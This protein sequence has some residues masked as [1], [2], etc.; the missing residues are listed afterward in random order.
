MWAVSWGAMA[1]EVTLEKVSAMA[2]MSSVNAVEAVGTVSKSLQSI[3]TSSSVSAPESITQGGAEQ[4]VAM[5]QVITQGWSESDGNASLVGTQGLEGETGKSGGNGGQGG[6]GGGAFDACV[7]NE[8]V[9]STP[10]FTGAGGALTALIDS[11]Y[12]YVI[13]NGGSGFNKS[14]ASKEMFG[15][16]AYQYIVRDNNGDITM[17]TFGGAG[18]RPGTTGPWCFTFGP[19]GGA[20]GSGGAG[21]DSGNSGVSGGNGDKLGGGGGG[22]GGAG[23]ISFFNSPYSNSEFGA[24]APQQP[25]IEKTSDNAE[26]YNSLLV[27]SGNGNSGGNGGNGGNGGLGGDYGYFNA[28]VRDESDSNKGL[29]WP[30]GYNQNILYSTDASQTKV[31]T[32]YY[33]PGSYGDFGQSMHRDRLCMTNVS[34][35]LS[36]KVGEYF[37]DGKSYSVVDDPPP[38]ISSE[39]MG[40]ILFFFRSIFPQR[41][42]DPSSTSRSRPSQFACTINSLPSNSI[43]VLLQTEYSGIHNILDGS[44]GVFRGCDGECDFNFSAECTLMAPGPSYG[45]ANFER[46]GR[47]DTVD[48][49]EYGGR[50]IIP[51]YSLPVLNYLIEKTCDA[52]WPLGGII[53]DKSMPSQIIGSN[54]SDLGCRAKDGLT[55]HDI[56]EISTR[57]GETN[58]YARSMQDILLSPNSWSLKFMGWDPVGLTTDATD[59]GLGA[60]GTGGGGGGGGGGTGQRGQDAGRGAN[61]SY[62][63]S[64]TASINNV[65]IKNGDDSL[66]DGLRGAVG[67]GTVLNGLGKGGKG[68]AGGKHGDMDST[69]SKGERGENGSP[70]IGGEG[71]LPSKAGDTSA[72]FNKLFTCQLSVQRK[73]QSM[74]VMIND[75]NIKPDCPGATS[76]NLDGTSNSTNDVQI[77]TLNL[78]GQNTLNVFSN[79][80][81]ASI[82]KINYDADSN[83]DLMVSYSANLPIGQIIVSPPKVRLTNP[84][85]FLGRNYIDPYD[86][87]A[88]FVLLQFP[89]LPSSQIAGKK[90]TLKGEDVATGSGYI[91]RYV[92]TINNSDNL[93]DQSSRTARIPLSAFVAENPCLYGSDGVVLNMPCTKP[94]RATLPHLDYGK[95]YT[96]GIDQGAFHMYSASSD[97]YT[98]I[99]EGMYTAGSLNL[100]EFRTEMPRIGDVVIT[101]KETSL[102]TNNCVA[103]REGEFDGLFTGTIKT[104]GSSNNSL[105]WA[106]YGNESAQ[107]RI[108]NTVPTQ[109]GEIGTS[110]TQLCIDLRETSP[111]V[112]VMV[113]SVADD[114]K[115]DFAIVN[116]N[117]IEKTTVQTL[118]PIDKQSNVE[119]G[120]SAEYI[121]SYTVREQGYDSSDEGKNNLLISPTGQLSP[122]TTAESVGC[123]PL[124]DDTLPSNHPNRFSKTEFLCRVRLNIAS[125]ESAALV[126][127]T[128]T[129]AFDARSSDYVLVSVGSAA[130][131][132]G[133][134]V[135]TPP[136][137]LVD[138]STDGLSGT[139][140]VKLNGAAVA[141]CGNPAQPNAP[142]SSWGPF[143][144]SGNL[145]ESTSLSNYIKVSNSEY[146]ITVNPSPI[147]EAAQLTVTFTSCGSQK[148]LNFATIDLINPVKHGLV[149][150]PQTQVFDFA[151]DYAAAQK[152]ASGN[153]RLEFTQHQIVQPGDTEAVKWQIL[154]AKSARTHFD[155]GQPSA[156]SQTISKGES[157]QLFL[158]GD[159][160][161]NVIFVVA[162]LV[163]NPA[164]VS[165]AIV[166]IQGQDNPMLKYAN[167]VAQNVLLNP[168]GV[169]LVNVQGVLRLPFGAISGDDEVIFSVYGATSGSTAVTYTGNCGSQFL[170][171]CGEVQIAHNETAN[172]ILVVATLKNYPHIRDTL[173]VNIASH[174]S[175]GI[176]LEADRQSVDFTLSPAEQTVNLTA[177]VDLPSENNQK[178]VIFSIDGATSTVLTDIQHS[179]LSPVTTATLIIGPDESARTI[180]ITAH[181]VFNPA[182]YATIAVNVTSNSAIGVEFIDEIARTGGLGEVMTDAE[183][184]IR[185]KAVAPVGVDKTKIKWE[186]F[187]QT[188]GTELTGVDSYLGYTPILGQ[189]ERLAVLKVNS[190]EQS[191]T[192][193]LKASFEDDASY[194]AFATLNVSGVVTSGIQL[195]P[196][197]AKLILPLKVAPELFT[198]YPIFDY[199]NPLPVDES[200]KI[201]YPIKYFL[202]PI[203]ERGHPYTEDS[204]LNFNMC[205]LRTPASIGILTSPYSHSDEHGNLYVTPPGDYSEEYGLTQFDQN[206]DMIGCE[207][208]LTFRSEISFPES[209]YRSE[210]DKEKGAGTFISEDE[211]RKRVNTV[212]FQVVGGVQEPDGTSLY[213]GDWQNVSCQNDTI[214]A[215][216]HN[217]SFRTTYVE[218][219]CYSDGYYT[220]LHVAFEEVATTLWVVARST[221]DQSK[222]AISK[223]DVVNNKT[224]GV[225]INERDVRVDLR[226]QNSLHTYPNN[227]I[228][229]STVVSVPGGMSR[230]VQWS[231]LGGVGVSETTSEATFITQD[232]VLKISPQEV[233][234]TLYV[235]ARLNYDPTKFDRVAVRLYNHQTSGVR[236]LG[237]KPI[238]FCING[239]SEDCIKRCI[240]PLVDH[241][242]SDES[243]N[244]DEFTE[245]QSDEVE[246]SEQPPTFDC[247]RG[248]N[249]NDP[250]RS[251]VGETESEGEISGES[252]TEDG[253]GSEP[254]EN[255]TKPV[256]GQGGEKIKPM[257]YQYILEVNVSIPAEAFGDADLEWTV[258]GGVEG[259]KID[260]YYPD[261]Y[262]PDPLSDGT[263]TRFGILTVSQFES[264]P[265]LNIV[266]RLKFDPTR[267]DT[268]EVKVFGRNTTGILVSPHYSEVSVGKRQGFEAYIS[269]PFKETEEVVWQVF[270]GSPETEITTDGILIIDPYE[271]S[272]NVYV[273]ATLVYD[274]TRF[275]TAVVHILDRVTSGVIISP[276]EPIISAGSEHT[277]KCQ[278]FVPEH[279]SEYNSF[280]ANN[281]S[282]YKNFTSF[283]N[284]TCEFK[285]FGGVEGTQI[286]AKTGE[287]KVND[288]ETS[289][290]LGVMAYSADEPHLKD[291]VAVQVSGRQGKGVVIDNAPVQKAGADAIFT[292]TV[293]TPEG[294]SKDV[295]WSVSGGDPKTTIDAETG[296]LHVANSELSKHLTVIAKSVYNPNMIDVVDVRVEGFVEPHIILSPS[297]TMLEPG[298]LM[299]FEAKVE[300]PSDVDSSVVW[301]VN[302]A[303]SSATAIING[304]LSIA[305]D[306]T[307][308]TLIVCGALNYDH[309]IHNCVVVYVSKASQIVK[310]R[311]ANLSTNLISST[312]LVYTK[313]SASTFTFN[314]P[315]DLRLVD[316]IE[317]DGMQ[318][319]TDHFTLNQVSSHQMSGFTK[320]AKF[321]ENEAFAVSTPKDGNT[322]HGESLVTISNEIL[323]ALQRGDHTITIHYKN[324]SEATVKPF[325]V[326]DVHDSEIWWFW[327]VFALLIV[328]CLLLVIAAQ[329]L[330][331][332]R[333]EGSFSQTL[334]G[335]VDMDASSS[336]LKPAVVMIDILSDT[337]GGAQ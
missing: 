61:V 304:D 289:R 170:E 321:N 233:A 312:N 104:I 36:H 263:Y 17:S 333:S 53:L 92:Y 126:R 97:S 310:N 179:I 152:D 316:S 51:Y 212:Q 166:R 309:R 20:G 39:K 71:G 149:I 1:G 196:A 315:S 221:Y 190:A 110:T 189:S 70:G 226:S 239:D 218:Q 83:A 169:T 290:L 199:E 80:G 308:D 213:A 313:D 124:E 58:V 57:E 250:S 108:V 34:W 62:K 147:E 268:L 243:G 299:H 49:D 323:D 78:S 231:V 22:G 258:Y 257:L 242:S 4:V 181:S 217:L 130:L 296:L 77:N 302:G 81:Q 3:S 111:V 198:S 260:P 12:D 33:D 256:E 154:G 293:A 209:V 87:D 79:I 253:N 162:S 99:K 123:E 195:M 121:F 192:I 204:D 114:S 240:T 224:A 96:V 207:Q 278:V 55:F 54:N 225:Y 32:N 107:T 274:P 171:F 148:Y 133:A 264:S 13:T 337:F 214:D 219:G 25:Q 167:N 105:R 186:V 56:S 143:T 125:S 72:Q 280:I 216:V 27:S 306:E 223:V 161:A 101:P 65:E 238:Y 86:E 241:G 326:V 41:R 305:Y 282:D 89:R 261:N 183:Y 270:G 244:G 271:T 295:R 175:Q 24:P 138:L 180:Y 43:R 134:V 254:T 18:G 73:T 30:K 160:T 157:G 210:I 159:E 174:A 178:G 318:V 115:Y 140:T 40:K 106:I 37:Y 288:R 187:G 64:A 317:V 19:T 122:Q 76:I 248:E 232:G 42:C 327:T 102:S 202:P 325:K 94:M 118:D 291:A 127:L 150:S 292:A 144:L 236:I 158:G 276:H 235:E 201:D 205:G 21:G 103:P 301:S 229:F 246:T 95:K 275:D 163:A 31:D 88:N 328:L 267:F 173:S 230:D 100:G 93:I 135:F 193:Y 265:L 245:D 74:K 329:T 194:F 60:A 45:R 155:N 46:C 286:N 307:G 334:D 335:G 182:N 129:S 172:Q 90:I 75:F 188:S 185:V 50:K 85:V 332:K 330:K 156:P 319:D 116:V 66:S 200:G 35:C 2:E 98:L 26:N 255:D 139:F 14:E 177:L 109:P 300:A 9:Q 141:D 91:D 137:A 249:A 84:E 47:Y 120:S 168:S 336:G 279:D 259:T 314:V 82:G 117:G 67:V 237:H 164:I 287:L 145:N 15:Y 252:G 119:K 294:E 69:G 7:A 234:T 222:F 151:N 16:D 220:R 44:R 191:K 146:R 272:A 320:P 38:E 68:G 113:Q 303:F 8:Q 176:S 283:E 131:D 262:S 48:A 324:G 142:V 273:T 251:S 184:L 311:L 284:R 281:D 29:S 112:I 165:T 23:G 228:L 211:T 10:G 28:K 208:Q 11:I 128:A 322:S 136:D 206:R 63:N 153:V 227:Q 266:A 59:S 215:Y 52:D 298:D 5:T 285:L 197:N 277:L 331:H 203:L 269:V 297:S 6:Y 247:I 132:S